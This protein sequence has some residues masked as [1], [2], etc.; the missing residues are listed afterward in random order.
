MSLALY[1]QGLRA[2]FDLLALR[3]PAAAAD[4]AT[5]QARCPA[6]WSALQAWCR[7]GAGPGNS[8]WARPGAPPAVALRLAVAVL[9][10]PDDAQRDASTLAWADA[11][12]RD[13]DGSLRLAAL[14]GPGADLRLRLGVKARDAIWWRQRQ[15]DDPWDAGWALDTPEAQRQWR[16]G[17]T[18]RRATLVLADSRAAAS[19]QPALAALA[20][21]SGELRH[22]VRWLWVGDGDVPPLPGLAVTRIALD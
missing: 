16:V 3:P 2:R 17:F 6:A 7:A 18:P 11:L 13:L 20:A 22:P 21:R 15:P 8:P 4:E 5:C 12:A 1:A 10:A 19:L 9:Q 14:S